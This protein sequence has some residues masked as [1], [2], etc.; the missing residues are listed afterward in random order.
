MYVMLITPSRY[1][2][3]FILLIEMVFTLQGSGENHYNFEQISM[4]QGLSQNFVESAYR[5]NYGLLWIGT[6]NGLNLYDGVKTTT[7]FH[8][9]N[10]PQSIPDDLIYFILQDNAE[11]IWI[12]TK[13]GLASYE[14]FRKSFKTYNPAKT[15]NTPVYGSY[16]KHDEQIIFGSG[17]H[18]AIYNSTTDKFSTRHFSGETTH[19]S[20]SSKMI[21][22][23][24]KTILIASRWKGLFYCDLNSGKLKKATFCKSIDILDAF[25]DSNNHLWLSVLSKGI[26]EYN[27]KK[28]QLNH[29]TT[30]NSELTNNTVLT[31][32]EV[33][34]NLW[35]GTDGGGINIYD[36]KTKT[37][38]ILQ[39][40][41]NPIINSH[42]NSVKTIYKD[43]YSNVWIGTIRGGLYSFKESEIYFYTQSLSNPE[44]GL[45]NSTVLCI[46]EDKDETV[47]IGTD[48]GGINALDNKNETFRHFESTFTK[49]I[50]A[51]TD[52][53]DY[54]L[55]INWY[56]HGLYI[57]NKKM[58]K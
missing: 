48:G 5:D 19:L 47:W 56:G 33:N 23:D 34:D 7:F 12:G 55:L 30:T 51:I 57:F 17:D 11:N 21:P 35:F 41:T 39:D 44:Y 24:D 26:Y 18:I 4:Q 20:L 43:R 29:F 50:N 25:I 38:S 40:V 1:T 2:L 45:S 36:A 13:G 14:P 9:N 32:N 27:R 46:T 53:S 52:F 58:N 54:E 42:L 6:K 10:D 8:D 31:I 49:K 16:L 28:Q 3:L 22:W 37:L 15:I